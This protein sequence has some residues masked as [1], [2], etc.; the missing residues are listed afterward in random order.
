MKRTPLLIIASV[1]AVIASSGCSNNE[2]AKLAGATP[3]TPPAGYGAPKPEM[4]TSDF[5]SQ[6]GGMSRDQ[7]PAFMRQNPAVLNQVMTGPD[8][9]KLVAIINKP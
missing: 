2:T 7:R 4:S 9:S 3:V 5:L 1:A 6:L 8:K